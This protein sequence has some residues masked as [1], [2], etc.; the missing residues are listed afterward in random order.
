MVRYSKLNK[1]R[2]IEDPFT[3][4]NQ[5]Q[6]CFNCYDKDDHLLSPRKVLDTLS[7]KKQDLLYSIG[8]NAISQ[9]E[10]DSKLRELETI[11]IEMG[12]CQRYL[13]LESTRS[14]SHR[15]KNKNTSSKSATEVKAELHALKDVVNGLLMDLDGC[16]SDL[17]Q[18][19]NVDEDVME[20][21]DDQPA[22]FGI[23]S[24]VMEGRAGDGQPPSTTMNSAAELEVDRRGSSPNTSTGTGIRGWFG[25]YIGW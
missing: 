4:R 18:W 9:I 17:G 21:R 23:N 24:A 11:R 8:I 22:S 2:H 14:A 7:A 3:P 25:T 12:V 15:S 5:R 6:L 10:K 1:K 16:D 13:T 20:E 19:E